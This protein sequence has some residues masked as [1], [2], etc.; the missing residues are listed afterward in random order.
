MNEQITAPVLRVIGS[1]GEQL[2]QMTRDLALARAKQQE[3]DLVEIA[4]QAQ[5]PVAKIINYGAFKFQLEKQERKQKARQKKVDVKGIRL[6]FGIDEHDFQTKVGHAA[7]FL[8]ERHKVKIELILRGR[9]QQ[10]R[11]IGEERVQMFIQALGVPSRVEMP[12]KQ[13]GNRLTTIIAPE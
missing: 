7:R 5:P 8:K 2:G 9:E 12:L 3:L 13:L 6:S 1:D 10:H 4:P 11:A